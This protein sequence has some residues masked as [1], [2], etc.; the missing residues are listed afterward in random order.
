MILS[1]YFCI[2]NADQIIVMK[3]GKIVEMGNYSALLKQNG[4]YA[5]LYE[6][7]FEK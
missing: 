6:S 2:K 4:F 3:E 1:D 5:S 7:Q